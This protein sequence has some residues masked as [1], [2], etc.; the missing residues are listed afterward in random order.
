VIEVQGLEF[1]P[2]TKREREGERGREREK[3]EK[4]KRKDKNRR[5]KKFWTDIDCEGTHL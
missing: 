5:Q 1:N 2:S 3:E 4:K